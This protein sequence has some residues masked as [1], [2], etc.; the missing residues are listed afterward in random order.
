[1]G[2]SPVDDNGAEIPGFVSILKQFVANMEG[3]V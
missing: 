2:P 3:R 1:M